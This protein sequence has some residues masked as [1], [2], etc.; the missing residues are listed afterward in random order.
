MT[1]YRLF[2]SI[3]VIGVLLSHSITASFFIQN[4]IHL[5]QHVTIK[6]GWENKAKHRMSR[7]HSTLLF[8]TSTDSQE[9]INQYRSSSQKNKDEEIVL[10][11]SIGAPDHLESLSVGQHLKAFRQA[12]IGIDKGNSLQTVP[13]NFTIQKVSNAPNVFILR[14]FLSK[15]ECESVISHVV[16]P[17]NNNNENGMFSDAETVTKGD[18]ISRKK[19]KVAWISSSSSPQCGIISMMISRLVS[20]IANIMLSKPVLTNPTAGVED[21]QVLKYDVGGE[22]VLHHDG[23]PRILTVIYYGTLL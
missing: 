16:S 22:F 2:C 1:N 8:S 7:I 21:L 19:C 10:L 23:E 6:N 20:S 4:S 9:K 15:F 18:A 3:V 17:S 14:D 13:S 12:T 11:K 5:P